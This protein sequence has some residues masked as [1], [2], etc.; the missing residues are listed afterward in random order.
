MMRSIPLRG[1]DQQMASQ[2]K[3]YMQDDRGIA[4]IEQAVPT[5]V[6]VA[7][8]PTVPLT[9]FYPRPPASARP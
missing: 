7:H 9:S 2:V 4:F 1:F 6:R 8:T 5:K 3:T